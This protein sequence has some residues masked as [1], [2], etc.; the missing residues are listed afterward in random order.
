MNENDKNDDVREQ[1]PMQED[2]K[3]AEEKG[4]TA[5]TRLRFAVK[6]AAVVAAI[7]AVG[8]IGVGMGLLAHDAVPGSGKADDA[9]QIEAVGDEAA[10]C[11]HLWVPQYGSVHHDAVYEQVW[12]EPVYGTETTYHT[13]CNTCNALIDGNA[14]QHIE[15][16]GHSGYSTDVPTEME[17]ETLAISRSERLR[18]VAPKLLICLL[19]LLMLSVIFA[20]PAHAGVL[21]DLGE[22]LKDPGAWLVDKFLRDPAESLLNAYA[23]TMSAFG[24]ENFLTG[25]FKSLFGDGEGTD[26]VWQTI[27]A[28][29]KTLIVP[30]AG[31]ILALVMLVQVVKISQ[32]ID[33]TATFPAVKEIVFL[34]V[35]YVIIRFLILNSIDICA[36]VFDLFNEITKTIFDSADPDLSPI[37]IPDGV[38]IGNMFIIPACIS[39][40]QWSA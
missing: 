20:T 2:V 13:V 28:V 40:P 7:L 8:Y 18:R 23:N 36:A 14:A 26:A 15:E 3:A 24:T 38:G 37:T 16:T 12:H 11:D 29:H 25:S 30:L 39:S 35:L 33:S 1:D 31:S 19:L 32:R 34:A 17:N 5:S 9:G 21:E 4:K 10:A 22:I 27:N 6:V